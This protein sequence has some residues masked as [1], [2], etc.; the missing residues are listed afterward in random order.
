MDLRKAWAKLPE[1]GQI[2]F[3][4]FEIEDVDRQIKRLE[5]D[6]QEKIH[7]LHLMLKENWTEQE[8][9]DA[10]FL[11]KSCKDLKIVMPEGDIV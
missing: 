7:D 6:K 11:A 9:M 2:P 8:L 1:S 4:I 5:D 3:V 10:G